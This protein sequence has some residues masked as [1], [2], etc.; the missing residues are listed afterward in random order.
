MNHYSLADL[1]KCGRIGQG[2]ISKS[3]VWQAKRK[4]TDELYALKTT[5]TFKK[6][7][8]KDID[9][10]FKPL[11]QSTNNNIVKH[12]RIIC[13]ETDG[14]PVRHQILFCVLTIHKFLVVVLQDLSFV[15]ELCDADLQKVINF[16]ITSDKKDVLQNLAWPFAE[17]MGI[18][19]EYLLDKNIIHR[20]IKPS[21]VLVH[22][23]GRDDK[24]WIEKLGGTVDVTFKLAGFHHVRFCKDTQ[25]LSSY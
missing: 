24:K 2:E 13:G 20:D 3:R 16:C 15:M 18:A 22:G 4:G 12:H 14:F 23:I 1:T 11:L 25:K 5:S 7:S 8:E 6:F 10:D 21:S 19:T 17:Q 9:I